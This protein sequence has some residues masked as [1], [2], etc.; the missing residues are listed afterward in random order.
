MKIPLSRYSKEFYYQWKNDPDGFDHNIVI[1]YFFDKA[2][3]SDKLIGGIKRFIVDHLLL[4]SHIKK[5][6]EELFW[7]NNTKIEECKNLGKKDEKFIEQF[8]RLPFNLEQGPLYR[9]SF[10]PE[11]DRAKRLL[12]LLHNILITDTTPIVVSASC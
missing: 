2:V 7:V 4:G 3:R 1:D 10:I 11:G 6:K 12:I 8:K 5:E 9:F